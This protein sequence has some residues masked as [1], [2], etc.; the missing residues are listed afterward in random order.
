MAQ[1]NYKVAADWF[2]RVGPGTS[3]TREAR[4]LHGVCRYYAGDFAGARTAFDSVAAA[5][6]LNEVFNNLGAAQAR[7][8]DPGAAE[9][10][11]RALEGDSSDP[12]YH[13]NLGWALWKA[14]DFEGA[15]ARFEAALERRPDDAEAAT[16]LDRCLKHVKPRAVEA[17]GEPLPRLKHNY[18]ERA[19]RQLKEMLQPQSPTP[20]P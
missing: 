15:A 17:P 18:E 7:L 6:P 12:V 5:V 11:R 8:D 20:A 10:F 3:N 19:W 13:F 1:K 16:M 2:Q 14:G 4:F 9:S